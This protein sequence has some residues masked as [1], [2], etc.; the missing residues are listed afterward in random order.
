MEDAIALSTA[1]KRS[2]SAALADYESLR[3]PLV[4]AVQRA[5]I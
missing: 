5:A 4:E 2:G 1:L 3:R